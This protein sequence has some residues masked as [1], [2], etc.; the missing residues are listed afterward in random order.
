MNAIADFEK[1]KPSLSL[2][3]DGKLQ[4]ATGKSRFETNWKNK[5]TSWSALVEKVS[6][7]VVTPETYA[8]Y[9][10]MTKTEQDNRKDVGGFV[11]GTLEDGKRRSGS[12]KSRQILTLDLDFAPYDFFDSIELLGDYACCMYTTHKHSLN[13]PRFRLLIPL[14][15][16]VSP[17]EYEAIARRVADD[18][19]IDYFDDTT[20]QPSRLMYWPSHSSDGEFIHR[21]IDKPWLSADLVLDTYDDWMDA[22]F[23]PESSRESGIRKKLADKQGDPT[24]KDGWIGA[25]CRT[26]TIPEVIDKYLPDV[27][28]PTSKEDRYTFAGGSTAA[29]LVLY[30]GGKF[31]FSNHG[32]DPIS[33]KLCNSFDLVRLHKY[34][35]LDEEAPENLAITKKPSFE[36]MIE[37]IRK[38]KAVMKQ[39]AD[40]KIESAGSDFAREAPAEEKKDAWKTQLEYTKSGEL[41]NCLSNAVLIIANDPKLAEIRKDNMSGFVVK[42]NVPWKHSS[43]MWVDGDDSQ[44]LCYINAVWG[45]LDKQKVLDAFVKVSEDRAFHPVKDYLKSL[46]EW[47]GRERVDSLLVDYLGADDNVYTREVTRKTLLAA[48]RRIYRPGCKFDSV[49]V[50]SGPQ[51]IG[52]STI[53][54][55]LGGRW[56]SDNLTLGDTKDKTAAEKLQGYWILE[57]GELAGMRKT[58]IETLRSFFSRQEDI[59]RAAYGRN[60][61]KHKRQC[62][63]IGTTNAD[64][65]LRDQ[66]GNRRFWPVRVSGDCIL[67]PWDLDQSDVDQIWAEV[68]V[69]S[70]KKEALVLSEEAQL[71][72][73]EMQRESMEED[74]RQGLVELYLETKLPE[75]WKSF[76]ID[77]RRSY[78]RDNGK[79]D[80]FGEPLEGIYERDSVSCAEIWCECF[81]NDLARMTRR[82]SFEI[83][84]IIKRIKGWNTNRR[85]VR[86]PGYGKQ[87]VYEKEGT[88][89]EPT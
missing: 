24:A 88:K 67:K 80:D 75:G 23:W 10:R 12:V 16:P 35:D 58:E 77:Q 22:S 4:I 83:A 81:G 65:F 42:G 29:G 44:L 20:Y 19:G 39:M 60:L 46:P 54:Q 34:G 53:A 76:T 14:D 28:T 7:A 72:A 11:G 18:I 49:L 70:K 64:G 74:D 86:I 84:A 1:Y 52:K 33:G 69:L 50:L 57:I 56:F 41:K 13:K 6:R 61:T 79:I 17:D 82:D 63:F 26:Y 45:K 30:E 5:V 87:K 66:E 89:V 62:I 78:Y 48:V 32:T 27:Y 3:Y 43:E 51:G 68:L 40:E 25:F 73:L 71:I 85:S 36:A 47:D 21:Y 2:K 31:A 9:M 59:Y 38:D 15:R 8:E 37:L 55:M